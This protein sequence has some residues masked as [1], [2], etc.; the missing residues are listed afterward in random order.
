MPAV[1]PAHG[2]V[3]DVKAW[4]GLTGQDIGRRIVEWAVLVG[5]S[6]EPDTVPADQNADRATPQR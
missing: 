2:A 6:S 4:A 5:P 1:F 3:A